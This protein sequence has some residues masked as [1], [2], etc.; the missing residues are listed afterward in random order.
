MVVS[1]FCLRF[2]SFPDSLFLAIAAEYFFL[3]VYHCRFG[4]L[5]NTLNNYLCSLEV[6]YNQLWSVKSISQVMVNIFDILSRKVCK[7]QLLFSLCYALIYSMKDFDSTGQYYKQF[8][9][10]LAS[11]LNSAIKGPGYPELT[12]TV[13]SSQSMPLP[14]QQ[15]IE[16]AKGSLCKLLR[17]WKPHKFNSMKLQKIPSHAFRVCS[18]LALII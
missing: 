17:Q 3:F 15:D 5:N 10:K 4:Y 2:M 7:V 12:S 16:D 9:A 18:I 6:P 1:S 13:S 14:L 11:Y 8:V